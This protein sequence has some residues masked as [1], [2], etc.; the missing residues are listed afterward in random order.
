MAWKLNGGLHLLPRP[1]SVE[2]HG[3]SAAA[4]NRTIE[5]LDSSIGRPQGY[6]LHIQSDGTIQLTGHD[7]AGLFYARQTLAQ[8]QRQ[9]DGDPLPLV[10]I[11]D[12]PDFSVR[13][14]M[15]DIS[16]DKVP[17]MATLYRLVDELA[18][19]KINQLQLYTEHTFAYRRHETVWKDASPM[20]GEE[21]QALDGYCAQRFIELVPNQNS[22]GH[23]ER[24]FKHPAYHHLAEQPAGF[25]FPWGNRM[26]TGFSLNP[27]DPRSLAFV[28]DLFD[29]LLP[30]FSSRL[31]NVGCDETFDIGLGHSQAAVEQRGRERVYLEFL[32]KIHR[33]VQQR[34]HMMMFWGDII[35]HKPELLGEL[36]RDL[37]ALNWGYE[38][39]HPFEKE[40][41]A[42]RE[43]GIPF[44]VC[45]GTSSWCS[46]AGRTDNALLNLRSAAAHG[47]AN[48]ATG[49][50]ITDWG[51]H[52]HLQY[53]PVSYI[54]LA[55]GAAYAWC[56][57]T[58]HESDVLQSIDQQILLDR[59]AR[60][61]RVL[62][63]LG[64]VY[65]AINEPLANGSRQFWALVNGPDRRKLYEQVTVE[66][67]ERSLE[68][69]D[70]AMA[71]FDPAGMQRDDADLIGDEIRNAAAMLR[72]ACHHGL[73]LRQQLRQS[74]K[75]LAEELRR[76]GGEH[77][78]LWLAR[79][80]IGGLSDSIARLTSALQHYNER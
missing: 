19:L 26:P 24:W 47:L 58:N 70:A 29:Q 53:L 33:A 18:A 6:R 10:T 64:N 9:C 75:T 49:Y 54:G 3:G 57:R 35:L 61:A 43:A 5:R 51:D 30:N 2:L 7:A 65:R 40:T 28:E 20:T 68:R 4:G 11:E 37:I 59:A 8:I 72:H 27:T 79:N 77:Q 32:L 45:P 80:R 16:R 74:A 78:R 62:A 55:A 44:Y 73:F 41:R 50:L 63:D 14:F 39:D 56:L 38:A 60:T 13:G 23:L 42:F 69:I 71:G 48:G 66:E 22:F 12:D 31:F 76:I 36:P 67:Y 46:I 15:L 25:V 52:G 1:R 17:T 21:I 34:G